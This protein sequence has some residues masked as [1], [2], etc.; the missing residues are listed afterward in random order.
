MFS[1]SSELFLVAGLMDQF[2]TE[3]RNGV[4]EVAD[5][6]SG[7]LVH[8]NRELCVTRLEVMAESV[9][10]HESISLDIVDMLNEV[11]NILKK[12]AGLEGDFHSYEAPVRRKE[13]R[14][15][16]KFIISEEQLLFFKGT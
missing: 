1:H 5:I 3:L 2:V 7:N 14:G 15:R 11:I 9:L 4:M 12:Q 16:P 6:L 13:T 10:S 8:E